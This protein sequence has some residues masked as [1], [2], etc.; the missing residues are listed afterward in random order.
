MNVLFFCHADFASNS[1]GHIAGFADGL[2]SLGHACAAAIPGEDRRSV[3]AL[4]HRPSLRPLTFSDVWEAP[5]EMFPDRG[6]ADVIHAWTPREHVRRVV[7]R[8]RRDMPSARVVVHLED[9]EEHLAACFSGWD[10]AS[11]CALSDAELAAKLPVYLSHPRAYRSFL[12]DAD[13]V[14]GIIETLSDFVPPHVPFEEIWPVVD[15][16]AYHPAPP[17]AAL[18]ASLGIRPGEKV[19]CYPGNSH[20]A[21][22]REIETLYEAVFLLNRHGTPCRL[23]RTGEDTIDFP[24]HSAP[25]ELTRHVLHLGFVE[26]ARLAGLLRLADVLV[27]PGADDVF[28][29]YR[30]PSKLPEFL[31]SGHPVIMPRANLGLRVL[32]EREALVL[33]TAGPEAIVAQCLR[34]FADAALAQRLATGGAAFARAHFDRLVNARRLERFYQTL[35]FSWR[36]T[37]RRVLRVARPQRA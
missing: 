12:R 1:M 19:L 35:G 18:R 17:D 7:N 15:F 37:W 28:N 29:R 20:F 22:A 9:N 36:R 16:A 26:H 11:L 31:A 23:I 13:G 24:L 6:P 27:Q 10:Y 30:L 8:C 34:V 3:V 14:T 21:N 4:G 25:E 5:A 33:E 2:R 32:P